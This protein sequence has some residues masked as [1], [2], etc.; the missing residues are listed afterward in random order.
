M[1]YLGNTNL[2]RPYLDNLSIHDVLYAIQRLKH[3]NRKD[4]VRYINYL[5]AMPHYE[6][7]ERK[8]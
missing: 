1:D 6:A 3:E 8:R 5:N 4:L 2:K 7:K